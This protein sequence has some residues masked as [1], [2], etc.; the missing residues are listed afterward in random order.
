[1]TSHHPAG[2]PNAARNL[3]LVVAAF[4]LIVTLEVGP[5]GHRFH[6]AAQAQDFPVP[7]GSW[8][9]KVRSGPGQNYAQVGSLNEGEDV[10]L[11]ENTGVMMNGY[12]WFRIRFRNNREG[13]KW[14]GILCA[15]RVPVD[16]VYKQC[17]GFEQ[18]VGGGQQPADANTQTVTYSCEEGIPL[19]VRYVNTDQWSKA[20]F[21]HDSFP[22]VELPQ[23]VSGSGARYSNGHY[24]LSTK[25]SEARLE[26]DGTVSVCQE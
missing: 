18:T 7:A 5:A 22:E 4:V 17:P 23:V 2:V 8:A 13:Y 3:F 14:G 12:P 6:A 16:G 10:V 1:M 25:G 26:W 21:S 19:I 20:Y 15:K 24:T 11:L 9:G